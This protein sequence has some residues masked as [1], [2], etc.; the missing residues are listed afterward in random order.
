MITILCRHCRRSIQSRGLRLHLQG[1]LGRDYDYQAE[2]K[3]HNLHHV[4]GQGLQF[5]SGPST[6]PAALAYV[7]DQLAAPA[8]ALAQAVAPESYTVSPEFLALALEGLEKVAG[9]INEQIRYGR[10]ILKGGS[11]PP[12]R[13]PTVGPGG[14]RPLGRPLGRPP[15][16]G[17]HLLPAAVV[18]GKGSSGTGGGDNGRPP[19]DLNIKPKLMWAGGR[20][21]NNDPTNSYLHHT[22]GTLRVM[23]GEL[24]LKPPGY[25]QSK[26]RDRRGGQNKGRRMSKSAPIVKSPKVNEVV[27]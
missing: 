5:T 26:G 10:S 1:H 4:K 13:L 15:G 19:F 3:A 22:N 27:Q 18:D 14:P 25:G 21:W 16:S 2:L 24:M 8:Q 7:T 12:L 6:V 20:H 9:E 11:S 17:K 23:D